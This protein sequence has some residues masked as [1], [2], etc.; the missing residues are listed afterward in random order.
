MS[1]SRLLKRGARINTKRDD[2]TTAL[3]LA[4]HGGHFDI[5]KLLVENGADVKWKNISIKNIT[6]YFLYF[7][8]THL[9]TISIHN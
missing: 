9:Y 1:V 8:P 4:A 3:I 2:S 7:S 6:T 5:V